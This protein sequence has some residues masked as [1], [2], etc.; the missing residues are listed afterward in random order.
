MTSHKSS[1]GKSFSKHFCTSKLLLFALIVLFIIGL[2]YINQTSNQ[3]FYS[4]SIENFARVPTRTNPKTTPPA[5]IRTM[6]PLARVPTR[7]N[8]KT[9]PPAVIRTMKPLARVPTRTNPTTTRSNYGSGST[10]GS[11]SVLES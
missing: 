8:P 5:V 3:G 11:E 7:T 10:Y 2:Y 4:D 6:K 9:T 1:S